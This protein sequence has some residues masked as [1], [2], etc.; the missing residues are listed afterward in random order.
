[1]TSI[2][3]LLLGDISSIASTYAANVTEP[4]H[5]LSKL[6]EE[7]REDKKFI[8]TFSQGSD[9]GEKTLIAVDG[10]RVTQKLAGGDLIIVGATVGEG[11]SSKQLFE[12]EDDFPAEAFAA[13]YPHASHNE[14]LA[15]AI[16]STLELRLFEKTKADVKIIDG[17]YIVNATSVLS[18]LTS[19]ESKIS[20]L[21]LEMNNFDE[22]GLLHGALESIL[23][24]R[25]EEKKD[26]VAVVKSDS[27]FEYSKQIFGK[28]NPM[29]SQISDR[30][31]A[32]RIL[33][34]GELLEPRE[35]DSN[36]V[37]L[38]A[39]GKFEREN[40]IKDSSNPKLLRSIL[41]G[42]LG[43]LN[44]LGAKANRTEEHILQTTYFKP[45][46]WSDYAPAVK[47]QFMF[48]KEYGGTA[49]D[50]A[51]ELIS[52]IDQDIMQ[53]NILEPWCQYSADR[54]AKDV[55]LGSDLIKNYLIANARTQHES[56]GLLRNYRT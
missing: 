31:L 27:S 35:T 9:I 15:G 5:A 50:R 45:T 33:R 53:E 6:G 28:A 12:T 22:D 16:M 20:D 25:R 39:L 46:N 18:A 24:P 26:Y 51:K 43:I 37:V 29:S 47:I 52:L 38:D 10:G 44:R 40:K 56:M 3:E 55:S 49:L 7:L 13:I 23:H 30:M 42:K 17:A 54:R 36:L 41:S 4:S 32:S 14:K 8:R 19:T 1:M 2:S 11:Y 34:S 48:F 21:V